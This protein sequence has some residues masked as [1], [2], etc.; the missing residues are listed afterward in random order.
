MSR[1]AVLDLGH[2][3][4]EVPRV[5]LTII[6]MFRVQGFTV[7]STTIITV[8]TAAQITVV[9]CCYRFMLFFLSLVGSNFITLL[10]SLW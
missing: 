8:V 6:F 5:G 2:I 9:F 1:Q 3:A 10:S 4:R 7:F